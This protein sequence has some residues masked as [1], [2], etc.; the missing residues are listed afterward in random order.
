MADPQSNAALPANPLPAPQAL[1]PDAPRAGVLHVRHRHTQRYTVVGN[2]L[3][4]HP[5]LSAAAIGIGVYIQSLPDGAAVSIKALTQRFTEGEITIT[6]VLKEL[7]AAG[8][9]V[10]QRVPLGGGRLATRTFF[11]DHPG[12]QAAPVP[13]P[14]PEQVT[15]PVDAPE[16]APAPTPVRTNPS[17]PAPAAFSGPAVDLLARLRLADPRLLLSARDIQRL[18]PAVETWL[19]R[20]ATDEQITR[21]LTASLPPASEPIHYPARFLEGCGSV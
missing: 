3:A 17:T 15:C 11:Y 1:P 21:T 19:A 13:D 16:P 7:V 20:A 5:R 18:V 10:R 4:Q 9:L 12:A 8:Y 6:R 14:V 2:H